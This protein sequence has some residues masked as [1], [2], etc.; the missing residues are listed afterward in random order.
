MSDQNH[1]VFALLATAHN[2]YEMHLADNL[3]SY[4]QL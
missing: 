4:S 3:N 1:G 2:P